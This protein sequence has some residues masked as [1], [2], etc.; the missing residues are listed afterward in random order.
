MQSFVAAVVQLKS[1]SDKAA[2]LAEASRL[3]GEA[4]DAGAQ[5]VALPEVFAWRGPQ[6]A[7]PAE[8]ETVPGPITEE[9][10]A[11]ARRLG[12]HIVAGSILEAAAG[13]PLP[14]NT[15]TLLAPDGRLLGAYRKIHLFDIDLPG[16]V[17][18]RESDLRAPGAQPVC[19]T[20]ELGRIGLAICYDLRFPE[21]F[22]A[23]ADRGAEIIVMPSA[24]T[25]PTGEAHWEPL[26]R[27]RAIENQCFV[28]APNQFGT[29]T[30]GFANYGNS[31]LVDPWGKVLARG[32][33]D[34]AEVLTAHL[35]GDLLAR[36]RRELP[37]LEHRRLRP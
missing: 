36:V 3:I 17:T 4:A 34:R 1:G 6:S 2:N 10:G 29:N 32:A 9:M 31:L 28:L 13:G 27:A 5:L 18:I 35:D 23:L 30:Q 33:D 19:V 15:T 7:E 21:L 11:L 25:K 26:L 20:T 14:F 22:R 37:C 24:F 16:R 12:I 8:A